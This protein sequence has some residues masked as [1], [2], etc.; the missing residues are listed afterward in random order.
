MRF[1]KVFILIVSLLFSSISYS[2]NVSDSLNS[3]ITNKHSSESDKI[4]AKIALANN[5]FK[6]NPDKALVEINEVIQIAKNNNNKKALASAYFHKGYINYQLTDNFSAIQ[7]YRQTINYAEESADS[8]MLNDTYNKLGL[9]YFDFGNYQKALSYYQKSIEISDVTRDKLRLS[10]AYNNI[11]LIYLEWKIYDIS[12]EYQ[13]KALKIRQVLNKPKYIARSLNNIGN[14]YLKQ[15]SYKKA[16]KYYKQSL[17]IKKTVDDKRGLGNGYNNIGFYYQKINK[18]DSALYYYSES[19]SIKKIIKNKKGLATTLANIG[20][21]YIAKG[22]I[23]RGIGYIKESLEIASKNNLTSTIYE[24]YRLLFNAYYLIHEYEKAIEYQ[25][26]YIET[27]DSVFS[28]RKYLLLS[29]LESKYKDEQNQKQIKILE[30][31]KTIAELEVKQLGSRKAVYIIALIAVIFLLIL[32]IVLSRFK[33]RTN[34]IL[35]EKNKQ[36]E[37]ANKL[38]IE[39]ENKLIESNA[40]KDKF[41]SIVS[42]DLKNPFNAILGITQI[43][44]RKSKT[45]SPDKQAYYNNIVYKSTRNLFNLLDNLLKWSRAQSGS[46]EYEPT[47]LNL[48]EVIK[49]TIDVLEIYAQEKKINLITNISDDIFVFSDINMITT[50]IRNLVSNSIKYSFPNYNIEVN[51]FE[52]IDIIKIMIKDHGVGMSKNQV[53]NLFL[54]HDRKTTIGTEDE[55]GTGLGLIITKE[56]AEKIGGKLIIESEKGTGTTIS[57]V[58]S[59][60][61]Y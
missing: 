20:E 38:L 52:T 17:E 45:L 44:S 42:H 8:V 43:L 59:N 41:F 10:K 2:D 40:S 13:E 3:I 36:L 19:I 11:G 1:I 16:Y 55:K 35:Q 12:L 18:Y 5:T 7:N 24:N 29:Q 57:L 21:V 53:D 48:S 4:Y 47:L 30:N 25:S 60:K 9:V 27:R 39:S 58:L 33:A 61:K 23:K 54:L 6:T 15:E 22:E 14:V 51:V 34:N 31:E 28:Q 26:K 46:I 56:F 37:M 32:F 50:I 49:D